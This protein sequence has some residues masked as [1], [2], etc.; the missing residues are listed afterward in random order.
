MKKFIL[1]TED[2]LKSISCQINLDQDQTKTLG[3]HYC[4]GWWIY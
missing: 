1:K 2:V 3:Q 4:G